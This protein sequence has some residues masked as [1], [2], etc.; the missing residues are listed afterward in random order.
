MTGGRLGAEVCALVGLAGWIGVMACGGVGAALGCGAGTA[1]GLVA[2]C[3][4]RFLKIFAKVN[5]M[6]SFELVI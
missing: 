3:G 1:A 6:V 2:C 5:A 4:G